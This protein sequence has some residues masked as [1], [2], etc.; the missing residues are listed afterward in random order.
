MNQK[1]IFRKAN[2]FSSL[3]DVIEK[4]FE[5]KNILAL[6][7]FSYRSS[8]IKFLNVFYTYRTTLLKCSACQYVYYC[9][10][11]CQKQSWLIHKLECKRIRKIS[12]RILPDSA[13][14][15][16]RL[17]F[18]LST[19]KGGEQ[20]AYYDNNRKFRKFKNLTSRKD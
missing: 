5:S 2:I 11:D 6:K 4:G 10:K 16:A 18:K 9:N 7:S 13:R 8:V 1:Y 12:P 17:I 14:F 15:L 20:V 19:S 3:Q